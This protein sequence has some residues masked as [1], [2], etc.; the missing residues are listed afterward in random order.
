M[1]V[2]ACILAIGRAAATGHGIESRAASN[3]ERIVRAFAAIIRIVTHST[4]VFRHLPPLLIRRQSPSTSQRLTSS[5][6]CFP[7]VQASIPLA[8]RFRIVEAIGRNSI[9]VQIACRP[10]LT[11]RHPLEGIHRGGSSLILRF[12][13]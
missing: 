1:G 12:L 9:D 6:R 13:G 5:P 10:L 4:V 8:I 7:T 3:H 11:V 2:Q